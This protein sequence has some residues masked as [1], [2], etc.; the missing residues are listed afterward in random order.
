M[1]SVYK[2]IFIAIPLEVKGNEAFG[3]ILSHLDKYS[4][5][6]KIV[7]PHNYH[8]TLKFL[9]KVTPDLFSEIKEYFRNFDF[10]TSK[11]DSDFTGLG[12]FPN[13][14]IPSVIWAGVSGAMENL[15]QVQ[16]DVEIFSRQFGF[17]EEARGFKPHVTL[18]RI[19]KGRNIPG[20][21]KHL[22]MNNGKTLFGT[23]NIDRIVL[24]ESILKE[25]GPV[26]HELAVH[27]LK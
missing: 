23:V 17:M 15:S 7:E 12:V 20:S 16:H 22:I 8:I 6:I 14:S 27:E 21:I 1:K 2:R 26:Y 18:G 4:S 13:M 3:R 19:R 9:G 25:T 11:T 5:T 24:Y 10:N